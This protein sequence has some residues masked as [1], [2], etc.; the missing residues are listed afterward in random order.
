MSDTVY[1]FEYVWMILIFV[2]TN[3]TIHHSSFNLSYAQ[4]VFSQPHIDAVYL[5]QFAC[6]YE[7]FSCFCLIFKLICFFISSFVNFLLVWCGEVVL[8]I[9]A[10][11]TGRPESGLYLEIQPN[12][13]PAK[14]LAGFAGC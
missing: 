11:R 3:L 10:P 1:V 14:F 4:N 12:P 5:Q 8:Q 6:Y 2:L 9:L 7:L 13:A